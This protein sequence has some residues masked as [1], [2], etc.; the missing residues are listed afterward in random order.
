[1]ISKGHFLLP[2]Y[3]FVAYILEEL[4]SFFNSQMSSSPQISVKN[5]KLKSAFS[6][7]PMA[8]SLGDSSVLKLLI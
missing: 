6:F 1:V 5:Q 3:G 2:R 4:M 7:W 8:Y